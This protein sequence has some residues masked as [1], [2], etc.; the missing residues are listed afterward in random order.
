M[1]RTSAATV[2]SRLGELFVAERRHDLERVAELGVLEFGRNRPHEIAPDPGDVIV[3]AIVVEQG[4]LAPHFLRR[5]E[6]E[7][8]LKQSRVDYAKDMLTLSALESI[9]SA[10]TIGRESINK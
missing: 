4:Q 1:T 7:L 6:A 2:C 5:F 3:D 9:R 10:M 8:L